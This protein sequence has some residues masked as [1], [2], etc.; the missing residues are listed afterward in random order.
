[1]RTRFKVG[2]RRFAIGDGSRRAGAFGGLSAAATREKKKVVG[3]KKEGFWH[4]LN[5]K[6]NLNI[7]G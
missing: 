1:M 7:Y 3:F 6:I 5:Y 2:R 4:L